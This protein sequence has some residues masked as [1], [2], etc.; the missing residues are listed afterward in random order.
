MSWTV[1]I[2]LF[3]GL[4]PTTAFDFPLYDSLRP[5]HTH[6]EVER[7]HLSTLVFFVLS[8]LPGE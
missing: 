8:C 2:K 5:H 7:G 4:A 3:G 1:E 6:S